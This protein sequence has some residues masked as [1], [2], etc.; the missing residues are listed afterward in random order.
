MGEHLK[1]NSYKNVVFPGEILSYYS[2]FNSGISKISE[3]F[4]EVTSHCLFCD[5]SDLRLFMSFGVSKGTQQLE[6]R[7]SRAYAIDSSA[8]IHKL[9]SAFRSFTINYQG[10]GKLLKT[11]SESYL[12]SSNILQ[13]TYIC[14]GSSRRWKVCFFIFLS[15]KE[16][17][18]P[19]TASLISPGRKVIICP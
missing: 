13:W 11:A 10:Q 15:E 2:E 7:N 18:R 19:L 6:I 9:R 5:E 8:M 12:K 4:L 1:E 17:T 3:C 14:A 16:T